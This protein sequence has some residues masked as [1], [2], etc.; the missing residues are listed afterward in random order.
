MPVR[1]RR[2]FTLAELIICFFVVAIVLVLLVNLYPMSYLTM[3]R[4]DH[5]LIA[6]AMAQTALEEARAFPY[7][8]LRPGDTEPLEPV[9]RNGVI[10]GGKRTVAAVDG[11]DPDL[12]REIVVHVEWVE[13]LRGPQHVTHRISRCRVAP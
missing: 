2:A 13:K 12:C 1:G 6:D 5:M 3:R 11:I 7:A 8:S 4:G 10:F 9:I